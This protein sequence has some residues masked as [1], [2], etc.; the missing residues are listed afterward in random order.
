MQTKINSKIN[1]KMRLGSLALPIFFDMLL[2]SLTMVANTTMISSVNVDWV[3]AMSAGNQVM[4]LFLSIFSFLS[5]GCSVVVAQA[6][7]AKNANLATR[8]IHLSLAF[9]AA[10]GAVC[11]FLLFLL[12]YPLLRLLHVPDELVPLSYDYLHI[13]G[14]ALLFDA[15]GIV[16]A[17]IIRVKNHATLILIISAGMNFV[18]IFGNGVALFGWFGLP[19]FGLKGVAI[20]TLVSRVVA[21][22]PLYY[23][24]TRVAKVHIF[25]GLFV[26]LRWEI[27][28][29]ILRVGLPSAGE[30]LLWM[31]QYMV[32]FGFVATCGATALG[33]QAIY[34]QIS[35]FIFLFGSSV[36]IANEILIGHLVGARKFDAAYNRSLRTLK[37][38]VLV[39][40]AVLAG[41]FLLRE[42]IMA[43]LG[44][45]EAHREM[46]RPLFWLSLVLES[47]RT[48]NIIMVNSLRAAGDAKFPF[49]VGVVF[50]WGVSLPIGWLVGLHWGWG[51]LGIWLG[52]CFDE[53]G[54]AV[55]N[56]WRWRSRVWQSKRLV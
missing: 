5:V 13:L 20:A 56:T 35:S 23:A 50:M 51:I 27:F 29:K 7:G 52:F 10:L 22:F 40:W 18:S 55:C 53:W 44:L 24:M 36:S 31:G 32:A 2:R 43:F 30:N 48:F 4:V 39:T 46:M 21:I 11:A 42:Q 38:G 37:I 9:N 14:L 47:G 28:S 26:N 34:M 3:A 19:V 1:T 41:F 17:A 16:M 6:L 54:R 25:A 12:A 49:A 15:I 45:P 8:A 33:V